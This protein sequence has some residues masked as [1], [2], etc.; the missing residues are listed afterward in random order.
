MAK[1]INTKSPEIIAGVRAKGFCFISVKEKGLHITKQV[2]LMCGLK[3]D[4][5][6]HFLNDSNYWAFYVNDDP[7]GFRVC[8]DHANGGFV[9]YSR[10]LSRMFKRSTGARVNNR[11]F[12]NKVPAKHN[13]NQLFE[14]LTSA[15][16][17]V[18]IDKRKRMDAQKKKEKQYVLNLQLK[19][20]D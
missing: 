10:E 16:I 6:V 18:I 3:A 7:D 15:T 20:T 5:F 11:F 12:I 2:A 4:K 14:I 17:E 8:A 9:L 19:K 1:I 13:D